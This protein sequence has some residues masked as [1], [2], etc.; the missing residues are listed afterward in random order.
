MCIQNLKTLSQIGAEK[1]VT[2][3]FVGEKENGQIKGLIKTNVWLILCYTEQL[4]IPTFVPNFIILRQVA[5]EKSL[6]DKRL[7]TN[8]HS[9]R[10]D[11]TY[12]PPIYNFFVP[13]NF[14]MSFATLYANK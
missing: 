7:H 10:K 14:G 2:E 5:A 11:K 9:Y 6:T 1:S 3:I 8:T 4:V 13:Q 12:I